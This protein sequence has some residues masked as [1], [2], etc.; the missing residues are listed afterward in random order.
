LQFFFDEGF[1]LPRTPLSRAAEKG[2]EAVVEL[3]LRSAQPDFED[4]DGQTPLFE[5]HVQIVQRFLGS[6][7]VS[8]GIDHRSSD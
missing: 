5:L 8:Y 3:L 1:E 6:S 4:A 2:D 7:I